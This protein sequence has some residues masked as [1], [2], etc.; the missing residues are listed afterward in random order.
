MAFD[1]YSASKN[2]GSS[3]STID[4]NA[5]NEYVVETA[6]LQEKETLVGVVSMIVDL[7][8]QEQEEGQAIFTGDEDDEAAEIKKNPG[9]YFEDGQDPQT[10][11]KVR[12]KKWPQKPV[13]SVAVAV[14]FPEIM[15]NKGQFFGEDNEKPLRLWLGGQFFIKDVGMVVG[16]PTPLK[17]NKSLG[18]WSFDKK[19]LFYKMAAASKFVNASKDEVFLP[20]DIDKLLGEAYQFEAQVFF[21][22]N[23]GK[24]YYTENAKFVSAL[25]RGQ[26]APEAKTEYH[27]VQFNQENSEEA[28]SELRNH[29]KNTIKRASNYEGS[30]IQEQLEA[31]EKKQANSQKDTP[32]DT[33]SADDGEGNAVKVPEKAKVAPKPK[34]A[35]PPVDDDLDDD[36]PF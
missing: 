1:A 29:V 27:L 35:K 17:V 9:T 16:R 7:G 32:Q 12:Y 28:L 19:H 5:L 6:G 21:R 11:K 14:D 20:K 26:A 13:Q 3:G 31:L 22:E 15:L 36:I 25:G 23:D 33:D 34:K 10:K 18:E 8:T 2:E 4:W 30:K 24:Q